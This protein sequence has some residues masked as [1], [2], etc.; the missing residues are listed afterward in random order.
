MI[1]IPGIFNFR[2]KYGMLI[3]DN[4]VS[5]VAWKKG[6]FER[7]GLFSNDDAGI[8]RFLDFLTQN[9]KAFK[10]QGFSVMVNIIGEDYRFEKVAHLIGKY[11]T[12][13]HTKRMQQLFRGSSFCMSQVQG[14]EER[15]RREDWVLFS[16]VLTENKVSPWINAVVRG[17]RYLTGVHILSQLL[18]DSV[19]DAIDGN[20][21][22]NIL[23]MTI[24][25]RG[26]LR[27]TFYANGHLR[28]SRVSKI[29]DDSVELIASS[30][31]KE[32]ER[33]VQYLNSLKISIAGGMT[34]KVVS[35]SNM[36]GQLREVVASGERLK[37]VF[38]DAAQVAQKIGLKVPMENLGKDSSLPM[39]VMFS[40]IRLNQLARA[41]LV[42]YYWT[43]LVF[44]AAICIF[45]L[46][47]I[48]A[49]ITPVKYLHEGYFEYAGQVATLEVRE[50]ELSRQYNAE[51]SGAVGKP[52]SSPENMKAVSDLYSVIEDIVV[53]PTQLLY[54]IGRAL[55]RNKSIALNTIEWQISNT[56]DINEDVDTVVVNGKDLYQV[57]RVYGSFAP[58][59]TRETYRDV[60]DRSEK[61]IASFR[62]R[63]DIH[64]EVIE[65]P[66]KEISTNNLSGDLSSNA[67]IEAPVTRDFVLQ[68]IWKAYDEKGFTDI[69]DQS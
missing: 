4:E 55:R 23:L 11:K 69:I 39:H 37:F 29:N 14:R 28:F 15:G 8:A 44:K 10:D 34:I 16:G 66:P 9:T 38:E 46:Y 54:F 3:T 26:V 62:G 24:H 1:K 32:L 56:P 48:N 58:I 2:K 52:P 20:K 5:V 36:V 50:R 67:N 40:S 42:T 30:I 25:E 53:S 17:G 64:I 68:I 13:F 51:V 31:K 60:S 45:V 49:Y 65:E 7:L 6:S 41:Q 18:S 35:P 21:Q 61:L 33:T 63:D 43:N 47:G 12:D 22:G 27:Q 57:A 19:L 59:G